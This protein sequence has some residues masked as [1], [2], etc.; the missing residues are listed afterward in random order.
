MEP[1]SNIADAR[2]KVRSL[3]GEAFA[4]AYKFYGF[5]EIAGRVFSLLYFA[6]EPVT[7]DD[8][9]A[10]LGISKTTASVNVRFLTGLGMVRRVWQPGRKEYYLAER[11]FSRAMLDYLLATFQKEYAVIKEAIGE[12]ERILQEAQ[13]G[14]DTNG[15]ALLAGDVSLLEKLSKTYRG[16]EWILKILGRLTS[17]R[18]GAKNVAAKELR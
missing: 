11:D 17:P 12:S 4:S 10:Q 2:A 8:L 16:W 7:L 13:Q 9:V 1:T 5:S 15:P 18:R 3:M 6:A 14:V